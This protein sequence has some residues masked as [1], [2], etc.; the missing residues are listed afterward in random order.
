MTPDFQA[1]CKTAGAEQ[2]LAELGL[3]PAEESM[4]K[5]AVIGLLG[6]GFGAI[7][8]AALKG[9]TRI[10]AP[11][12][13]LKGM[14]TVGKGMGR[15]AALFGLLG[16]GLSAATAE[17]GDRLKA[18]GR[19]FLGG[20]AGGAAWAGGQNIVRAGLGKALGKTTSG[21]G[22]L[23]KLEEMGGSHH[24]LGLGSAK[25]A[26]KPQGWNP[27]TRWKGTMTGGGPWSEKLKRFGAK[28]GVG[29]PVFAGGMAASSFI[30]H[31]IDV[32]GALASKQQ[33]HLPFRQQP[34]LQR[35]Y[36]V[37]YPQGYG[38]VF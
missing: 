19:G 26:V 2:A 35:A 32:G 18:F 1:L 6:K 5:Q 9:A 25:S 31:E 17:P 28:A 21:L 7:G 37:G 11:K 4:E 34:V 10:G 33:D 14:E 22:R 36:P 16:G 13:A 27:F 38:R 3:R 8:G 29:I 30:P 20:A 23:A 15:D 24:W 12:W